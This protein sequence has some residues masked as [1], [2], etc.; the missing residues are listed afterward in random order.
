MCTSLYA[1]AH[2]GQEEDLD[3]KGSLTHPVL[4]VDVH[5]CISLYAG[6]PRAGAIGSWELSQVGAG[7]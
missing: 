4:R 7:I 6:A 1:S 5:V 3:P 2:G